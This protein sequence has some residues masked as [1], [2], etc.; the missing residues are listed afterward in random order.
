MFTVPGNHKTPPPGLLL[1]TSTG[2]LQEGR[3]GTDVAVKV[4]ECAKNLD[5]RAADASNEKDKAMIF[6]I[7]YCK[8]GLFYRSS[9]C[10]RMRSKGSRFTLGV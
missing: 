8:S 2:V 5:T 7:G 3:A 9:I 1:C 4:G 6:M 10:S